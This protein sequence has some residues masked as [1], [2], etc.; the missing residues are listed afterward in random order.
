MSVVGFDF[1]TTNSLISTIVGGRAINFLDEENLPIP[2]VV[3]Y[4]G[5]RT[6][7]GRKAKE[8]LAGAGLGVVG[9]IVRSPKS[10]LG[11]QSVFVDGIERTPV[12]IVGDVIS[13][14]VGEAKKGP[15]GRGLGPVTSA[16][17]TIPVVMDGQRR[18]ALR[19]AFRLAGLGIQAVRT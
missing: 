9:S 5:G 6:V 13:Y 17:V 18:A 15:R 8:K 10:L 3:S 4:A 12:D 16:V 7:V 2:S 1:G 11:R 19:D 14:V